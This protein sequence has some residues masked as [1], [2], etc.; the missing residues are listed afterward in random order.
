MNENIPYICKIFSVCT[1]VIN[2]LITFPEII[3]S[4]GLFQS[5]IRSNDFVYCIH[6]QP[7]LFFQ[8]PLPKTLSLSRHNFSI[9]IT[10][11]IT[12]SP[13][14]VHKWRHALKREENGDLCD[15]TNMLRR[16]MGSKSTVRRH[17]RTVH[18]KLILFS[19][20][21]FRKLIRFKFWV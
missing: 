1:K 2:I 3:I 7:T 15:N 16:M 11:G 20:V 8:R 12:L 10:S 5:R 18:Q 17:L 14:T 6:V 13:G 21:L 4:W 19:Y 9:E